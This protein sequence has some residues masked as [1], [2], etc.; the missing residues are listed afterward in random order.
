MEHEIPLLA[1]ASM[2]FIAC[3][4]C[5]FLCQ[6]GQ[7]NPLAFWQGVPNGLDAIE[8]RIGPGK[9]EHIIDF[10]AEFQGQNPGIFRAWFANSPHPVCDEF[11]IRT[12]PF[13]EFA[14][15]PAL[16]PCR[17]PLQKLLF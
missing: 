15:T 6:C 12:Q 13:T 4:A 11:L 8:I 1:H 17:L 3:I 2:S 16:S 5:Y 14:D 10:Q 9:A 7:A